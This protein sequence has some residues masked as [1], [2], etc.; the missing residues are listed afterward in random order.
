M[1]VDESDD[2][3]GGGAAGEGSASTGGAGSSRIGMLAL[4]VTESFVRP[5]PPP[6]PDGASFAPVWVGVAGAGERVGRSDS[7]RVGS[8]G[9]RRDGSAALSSDTLL[10]K[11]VSAAAA[12]A[13]GVVAVEPMSG[14]DDE[15]AFSLPAGAALDC[16]AGSTRASSPSILVARWTRIQVSEAREQEGLEAGAGILNTNT[17]YILG[18]TTTCWLH[19][20]VR[21]IS[22]VHSLHADRGE[23]SMS[24]PPPPPPPGFPVAGAVPF[25]AP[26]PPPWTQHKGKPP[27]PAL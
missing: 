5:P 2:G 27:S 20:A 6:P 12:A 7:C 14:A 24:G 10:G 16:A 23:L 1:A 9:G 15:P 13:G 19:V 25:L 21:V 22:L 18:I 11:S 26:V 4:V 8:L 17:I 3:G